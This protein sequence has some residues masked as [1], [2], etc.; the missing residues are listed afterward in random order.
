MT[1][2]SPVILIIDWSRITGRRA[3]HKRD[4]IAA[5]MQRKAFTLVELLVVI[6]IIGLLS[7]VAVVATNSARVKS[8]DAKRMADMRRVLSALSIYYETNGYY[9]TTDSDGCGD[10]D[11]G[12]KDHPLLNGRMPGI[13]D[14][15][16]RDPSATGNC[17]GYFYYRYPAGASGC[18]AAKGAYF[19]LGVQDME[20]GSGAYPSSPGWRCPSRDWQAE[21]EWVTGGFE[22]Q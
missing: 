2:P 11:V 12:N 14:N 8:R 10:W 22:W 9:P 16:A 20:S 17:S 4:N 3:T 19:V 18:D 15:G 7:T 21:M 5:Y 13:M 1:G 6:A